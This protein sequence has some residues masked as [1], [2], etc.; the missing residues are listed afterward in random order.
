MDTPESPTR[1]SAWQE[2]FLVLLRIA[3]GWHFL[4]EGLA[5][6]WEPSWSAGPFLDL[7]RWILA[8]LFR[9]AAARPDVLAAIATSSPAGLGALRACTSRSAWGTR[10][11]PSRR[12]AISPRRYASS[13]RSSIATVAGTVSASPHSVT[14]AASAELRQICRTNA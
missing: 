8:P 1:P 4:Y 6:L 10:R 12:G 14:S 5:K 2:A 13:S 3:I 7:S 11:N 9:W